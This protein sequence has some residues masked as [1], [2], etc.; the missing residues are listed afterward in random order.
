MKREPLSIFRF[1]I[2][3]KLEIIERRSQAIVEY[4]RKV[5]GR[6]AEI[7]G[8]VRL[9][10][11]RS[12]RKA[13]KGKRKTDGPAKT[14]E[15]LGRQ[16]DRAK[17]EE[18]KL[19]RSLLEKY[20]EGAVS[21]TVASYEFGRKVGLGLPLEKDFLLEDREEVKKFL[22]FWFHDF[23]PCES[24]F[25]PCFET[26]QKFLIRH[27]DCPHRANWDKAKA[28]SETMCEIQSHFLKGLL[29]ALSAHRV[30]VE[31]RRAKRGKDVFFDE[32]YELS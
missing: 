9:S 22:R 1:P 19:I 27:D 11:I 5:Y 28:P 12:L 29:A 25:H 23:V 10:K 2:F 7:V 13:L 16:L 24:G 8:R 26:C 20:G 32:S 17:I 14:F 15:F 30:E 6:G 21:M 31:T 3:D 4:F 18:A